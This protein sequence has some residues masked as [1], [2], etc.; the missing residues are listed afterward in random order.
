MTTTLEP[1][2]DIDVDTQFDAAAVADTS[3]PERS[4]RRGSAG[5]R[6]LF[7]DLIG[8]LVAYKVARES[9]LGTVGALLVSALFPL[10]GLALNA[11]EQRKLDTFG[12]T[13]LIGTAAGGLLS[14][15]F[16]SPRPTLI[17]TSVLP[18]LTF[19]VGCLVSLRR[20]P[21][22]FEVSL[23]AIGGPSS[24]KGAE[25]ARKWDE[26]D[27]FRRY[28]ATITMVWGTAYVLEAGVKIAVILHSSTG[29]ALASVSLLS[30]G[31]AIVL[32]LWTA[33][34]GNWKQRHG[35]QVVAR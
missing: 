26:L 29:H 20:K 9:G 3:K 17:F 31:I 28:F 2:T 30:T 23:A 7:F 35:A 34:Y 6:M 16:D 14:L 25:F 27:G 18:T 12:L 4:R 33:A 11:R 8:P 15:I 24:K 32:G 19:A 13:V 21:M 5:K 22:L 1:T 10:I